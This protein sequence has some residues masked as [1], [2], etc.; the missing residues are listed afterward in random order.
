MAKI[1]IDISLVKNLLQK[2]KLV[3]IPTE[4]VYG[5]AA[6]GLDVDAVA[7]I[8]KVKN[9][10]S[11]DPL[12]IHTDSIM[13]IRGFVEDIPEKLEL[14]LRTFSPGP[15]TV[16]LMKNKHIPD[17]VSSGLPRVAV[18]I[19]KHPLALELLASL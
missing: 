5:L 17:L 18:R 9:R 7:K 2:G 11:F 10:P 3:G 6:N 4:T 19:P 13:K 14:L 1:G 16:L 8:F 12:I 15:L